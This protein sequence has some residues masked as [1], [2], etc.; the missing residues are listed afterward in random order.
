MQMSEKK[1]SRGVALTS[2]VWDDLGELAKKRDVSRSYIIEEALREYI[3]KHKS[4]ELRIKS[5]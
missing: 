2:Q 1:K 3:H 4:N 5:D